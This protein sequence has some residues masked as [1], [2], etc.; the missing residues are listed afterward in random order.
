M[1]HR[2]YGISSKEDTAP[3]KPPPPQLLTTAREWLNAIAKRE[4]DD[5]AT[6]TPAAKIGDIP[7]VKGRLAALR[8]ASEGMKEPDKTPTQNTII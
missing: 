6:D 3:K 7:T 8:A 4:E 2:G 1:E 5:N